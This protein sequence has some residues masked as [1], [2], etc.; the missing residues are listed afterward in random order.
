MRNF[1]PTMAI[2]ALIVVSGTGQSAK[3]QTFTTLHTFTGD[4]DG[5]NPVGLTLAGS[6]ALY[7][8]T[9]YGGAG[10]NCSE[11]CGV[12]FKMT[13]K[14]SGWT[15]SPLYEFTGSPN[16]ANPSAGVSIGPTGALYGTTI[17]GGSANYGT[18]FQLTPP[19]TV[20][21]TAICYW[22]EDLLYSFQ[23]PPNDGA[24]PSQGL[25]I[26]DTAGNIYGMTENGGTANVGTVFELSQS[27]NGWN[28]NVYY[29]FG[30]SPTDGAAPSGGLVFDCAPG[31]GGL[32]GTTS[33]GG[34]G[35]YG[36]TIFQL[37]YSGYENILY[38]FIPGSGNPYEPTGTLLVDQYGNLYG[39]TDL[40]G[41]YG[42]GIVFELASQNGVW[43][44]EVLASLE[45]GLGP[46]PSAL[47]M[48]SAGNLYGTCMQGTL[49]EQ[50]NGMVFQLSYSHGGW[51]VND[52]HDFNYSDS[53]CFPGNLVLDGNGNLYGTTW[54]G[55]SSDDNCWSSN[56]GFGTVWQIT[57]LP[58]MRAPRLQ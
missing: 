9:S 3:A 24:S 54:S 56:F 51:H 16:G 7:G 14:D 55:G 34:A 5:G 52:L 20:C 31:C 45:C 15:L 13:E 4:R 53:G 11:G 8:A 44:F 48:D 21:K 57:N 12:V 35:E 2:L 43:N 47:V 50:N 40:G 6:G 30:Q 26:F 33:S 28:E 32:F 41:G 19:A 36:G 10:S 23:G 49:G 27:S 37:P 58:A 42:S 25:L 1:T 39:T 46:P 17:A 29:S 22:N 38:N 18:V